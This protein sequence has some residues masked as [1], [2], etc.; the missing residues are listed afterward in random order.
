MQFRDSARVCLFA[1]LCLAG[2]W[3]HAPAEI[4]APAPGSV[5]PPAPAAPS[6]PAAA[7][8]PVYGWKHEIAAQVG[9]AQ[10]SF[11][12]WAQGG[13]DS[14]AW[15]TSAL[16]QFNDDEASYGWTNRLKLGFGQIRAGQAEIKKST[17]LIDLE[18]VVT[19]KLGVHIDPYFA[20]RII[21]QFTTGYDYSGPEKMD[22]SNFFDPGYLTESAGFGYTYLDL[23][24]TRFGFAVRETVT[25]Y[26]P[27]YADDL[28]TTEIE[29]IKI[30]PGL[31]SVTD[32]NFKFSEV[33]LFTS[34]LALFSNLKASDQIVARWDNLLSINVA[35]YVTMGF[36]LQLLYDKTA[37]TQRQLYQA[38]TVGLSYQFSDLNAPAGK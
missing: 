1:A 23:V 2:S 29:K 18:S 24:K 19:Y 15:Q 12:N 16:G 5:A 34:S 8:T 9:L 37:S 27:K 17:D 4:L 38:T 35:K 11:S 26:Y 7:A 13:E 33:A 25:N 32:F 21:T 30:E 36:T 31:E 6:A 28:N 14:L 10:S 20:A 22:T 3:S